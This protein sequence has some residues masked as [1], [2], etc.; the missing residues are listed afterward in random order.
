[1]GPLEGPR[2]VESGAIYRLI[3]VVQVS[4]ERE[5]ELVSEPENGPVRGLLLESPA[6]SE[7]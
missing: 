4:F 7:P 6:G 5:D 2:G 1:M 3:K